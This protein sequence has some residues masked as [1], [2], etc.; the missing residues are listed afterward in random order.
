MKHYEVIVLPRAYQNMDEIYG[1]I[2]SQL[3]APTAADTLLNQFEDAMLS[4]ETMPY[5][6]PVR[7]VGAYAN[8]GYRQIFVGNFTIVYRVDESKQTVLVVTVRYARSDF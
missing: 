4:L 8:R 1:Y 7:R 6:F 5:R 3:F 2:A